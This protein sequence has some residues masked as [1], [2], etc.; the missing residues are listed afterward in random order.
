M[1]DDEFELED[2]MMGSASGESDDNIGESL[3]QLIDMLGD[4]E[5][6]KILSELTMREIR[7]LTAVESVGVNNDVVDDIATT[8]RTQ[9]ISHKRRGR[10]EFVKG[11]DAIATMFQNQGEGGIASKIK[12]AVGL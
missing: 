7:I 3:S 2:V 9:K 12:G 11:F 1:S 6:D 10:E 5:H 4:K 8:Y